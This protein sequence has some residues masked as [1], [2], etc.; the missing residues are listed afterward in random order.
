MYN[1]YLEYM[2][3]HLSISSLLAS[4]EQLWRFSGLLDMLLTEFIVASAVCPS[5]RGG[6][7]N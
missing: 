3:N 1:I 5:T 4:H 7:W 2:G 6:T